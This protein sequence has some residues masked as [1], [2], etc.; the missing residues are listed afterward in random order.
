MYKY[1]S[2][3]RHNLLVHYNGRVEE[4][5]PNQIIESRTKL[6]LPFLRWLNPPAPPK[7]GRP[8]KVVEEPPKIKKE[9]VNVETRKPK[10]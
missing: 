5:R 1:R 4:V 9:I 6:G 3:C 10:D 7:R 2:T 8:K